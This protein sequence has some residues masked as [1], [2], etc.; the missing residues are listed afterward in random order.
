MLE[1]Q[2]QYKPGGCAELGC[3]SPPG[4]FGTTRTGDGLRIVWHYR[5]ASEARTF[6][7]S[8]RLTG[9]TVAYDDVVDVNVRLWGDEWEQG[10]GRLTATVVAQGPVARA[11][12]HPVSVRGDVA[13]DGNRV[14]VRALDVPPGSFVEARVLFPREYLSDTSEAVVR[15]GDA[16]DRIVAEEVGAAEDYERERERLDEAVDDLPRTLLLLALL[17]LVPALAFLWLVH[18]RFGRELDVGYDRE[19]EQEP[20]TELEP[21]LVTSLVAQR[22]TVGSN[23]FTA[24]LFDLIRRGHYRAEAVTTARSIWGGLRTED[25]ADLELSRGEDLELTAYERAVRSVVD[26]LLPERLSNF[27]DRI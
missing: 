4:T 15:E 19:Y 24:T 8:Y 16:L 3:S 6:T 5:A 7:V 11:W 2:T 22:T 12:G 27:R 18:W 20:P 26:G 17:A 21:A 10:L 9:L 13:I 1:G 25:V 14:V 23:E